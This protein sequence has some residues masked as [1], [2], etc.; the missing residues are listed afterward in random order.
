MCRATLCPRVSFLY[1][2]IQWS[3]TGLQPFFDRR[4]ML[5]SSRKTSQV[6][7]YRR[8][9]L[10][11]STVSPSSY[12]QMIWKGLA[13]PRLCGLLLHPNLQ[14]LWPLI[15]PPFVVLRP[16][17]LICRG[18]FLGFDAA[19]LQPTSYQNRFLFL[20]GYVGAREALLG[21]QED[22]HEQRL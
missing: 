18:Q 6:L 21:L 5:I 2:Y 1:L 8:M 12:S 3:E 4:K 17:L 14:L 15:P 11:C 16:R 9:A 19:T 13:G 10:E 20:E 22:H 7:I